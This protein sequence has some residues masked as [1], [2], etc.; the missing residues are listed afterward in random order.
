MT[1]SK[2][3]AWIFLSVGESASG[4]DEIIGAADGINHAI[5]THKELQESLGWLIENGLIHKAGKKYFLTDA[6][7][8]IRVTNCRRTWMGTWDAVAKK[9]EKW[10][11]KPACKD[12]ITLEATR[13]A[14]KTYRKRFWKIVRELKEKNKK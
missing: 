1:K 6:G 13:S 11:E 12:S 14:Y 5:P 7:K 8:A 2:Q 3:Y 10:S 9:L 4:L